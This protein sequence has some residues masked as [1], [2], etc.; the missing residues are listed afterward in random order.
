MSSKR[1]GAG[2]VK[3]VGGERAS[4][5]RVAARFRRAFGA[6]WEKPEP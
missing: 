2:I 6:R 4:D 5:P 1:I 3:R